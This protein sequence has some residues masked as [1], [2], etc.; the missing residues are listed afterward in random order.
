MINI[1]DLVDEAMYTAVDYGPN[2]AFR[3]LIE[4]VADHCASMCYNAHIEGG[5]LLA[6]DIL[7]E[8][9]VDGCRNNK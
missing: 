9:D 8:F 6:S 3:Q 4:K 2:H 7:F 5:E 1:D